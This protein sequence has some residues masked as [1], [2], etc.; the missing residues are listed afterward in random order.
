VPVFVTL[1]DSPSPEVEAWARELGAAI[2]AGHGGLVMSE[3]ADDARVVVRIDA[4]ETNARVNPEPP[5]DGEILLMRGAILDG[6]NSRAFSLAYRGS[7]RPQAEALARNLRR[8]AA[9][10]QAADPASPASEG[11]AP[12]KSEPD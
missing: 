5:G 11:E 10:Q 1:P 2:A 3:S 4:V 7:A 9:E 12:S 8:F 6:E